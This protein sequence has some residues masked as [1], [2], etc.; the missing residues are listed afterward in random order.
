M[1]GR[2]YNMGKYLPSF[3][4]YTPQIS[5]SKPV[6]RGPLGNRVEGS[7]QGVFE[8]IHIQHKLNVES[9]S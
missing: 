6:G 9:N 8:Y 2:L 5:G 1:L 7:L 3:V 4:V